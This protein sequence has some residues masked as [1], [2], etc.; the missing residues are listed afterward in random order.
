MAVPEEI[1]PGVPPMA[2]FEARFENEKD[3]AGH[4]SGGPS[5]RGAD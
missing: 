4:R 2:G 3:G 5:S 1:S